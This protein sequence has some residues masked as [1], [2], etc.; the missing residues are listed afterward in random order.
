[1]SIY[2]YKDRSNKSY[3]MLIITDRVLVCGASS[4]LLINRIDH[5][6]SWGINYGLIEIH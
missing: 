5:L 1:M 6:I 2:N 3:L 4:V